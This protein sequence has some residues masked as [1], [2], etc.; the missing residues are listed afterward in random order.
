MESLS[1]QLHG[2]A[3]HSGR[4][5]LKLQGLESDWEALGSGRSKFLDRHLIGKLD[6]KGVGSHSAAYPEIR[7]FVKISALDGH[8]EGLVSFMH[9]L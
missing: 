2:D 1:E 8:D 5:A 7:E 3:E 9:S 6:R 4:K